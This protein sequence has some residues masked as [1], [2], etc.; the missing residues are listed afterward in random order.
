LR[1]CYFVAPSLTRGRVSNLLLLLVLASAVPRDSRPYFIVPILETPPTWRARFPYLYPPGIWW[2]SYT[3]RH[4]VP[5][6][7]PFTTRRD[8]GGG[9]H[10]ITLP[11]GVRTSWSRS[12]STSCGRQSVDQL[13]LG[14]GPPFGIL[15]Q[16]LSCSSSFVRQLRRFAINAS[17]LTRKR[18]CNL[19]LN[20]FWALPEQSHLSRS[21]TELRSY[22]TVSS[23]TPPTWRARF[24]YLYPP[25]TWWPSYT[26]RHWVPFLSPLTTRGDC[27][28]SILSRLHTG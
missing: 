10:S 9:I 8:Y 15:D 7:S 2:P 13:S 19:L 4:W 26:P 3:P 6:L 1:V 14:I 22:L 21:P 5:F 11:H 20:C 23:E 18:V 17:S 27:G 16:I 25:G 12:W 28:G 24:P